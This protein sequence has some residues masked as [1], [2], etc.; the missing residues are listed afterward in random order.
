MKNP[1]RR[2]AI[3]VDANGLPQ[4]PFVV[5]QIEVGANAVLGLIALGIVLMAEDDHA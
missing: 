5:K 2:A 3:E 1:G 4:A